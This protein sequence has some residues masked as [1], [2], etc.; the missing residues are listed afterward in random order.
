VNQPGDKKC[1]DR[2]QVAYLGS[3]SKNAPI[4]LFTG[5]WKMASGTT[6]TIHPGAPKVITMVLNR[7]SKG[8]M[9]VQESGPG[10]YTPA[11]WKIAF[12]QTT[13]ASFRWTVDGQPVGSAH[14]SAKNQWQQP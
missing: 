11:D 9:S 3:G 4:K 5:A 8:Q 2:E 12:A 13:T 7:T 14:Q 6:F 1:T 10:I